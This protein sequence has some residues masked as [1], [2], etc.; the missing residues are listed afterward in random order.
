[1]RSDQHMGLSIEASDFLVFNELVPEP[2]PHCQRPYP[3]ITEPSGKTYSGMFMEEYPLFRHELKSKGYAEEYLQAA[4]WSSG[5]C[6]FLGLKVY[7]SNGTEIRD[8]QW[9]EQEIQES[10]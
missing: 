1:M 8:F 4:P 2:C 3:P 10:L 7:D 6:L 5:P 9:T